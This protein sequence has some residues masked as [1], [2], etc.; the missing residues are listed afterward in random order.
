MG[1]VGVV[2]GQACQRA[3]TQKQTLG[4][5]GALE[6]GDIR[7]LEDGSERSDALVSD[8]VVCDTASEGQDGKR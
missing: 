5:G 8:A 6:V 3:L 2:R 1:E 4:G 7:L